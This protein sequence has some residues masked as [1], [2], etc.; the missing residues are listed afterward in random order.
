MAN[1]SSGSSAFNNETYMS[2]DKDNNKDENDDGGYVP[3]S[4]EHF[5]QCNGIESH[6]NTYQSVNV[7]SPA[8]HA[9]SRQGN[10]DQKSHRILKNYTYATPSKLLKRSPIVK[11]VTVKVTSGFAH[12]SPTQKVVEKSNTEP[13]GTFKVPQPK[14]FSSEANSIKKKT[15]HACDS[16]FV[17]DN[18]HIY[19]QVQ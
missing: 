8:Y 1:H 17:Y 18:V 6:N 10:E 2:I 15:D 9:F 12:I 7:Q 11:D 13:D 3:Q 5:A 16:V 19:Y 14:H 4:Y